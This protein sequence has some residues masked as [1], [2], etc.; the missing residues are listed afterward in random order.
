MTSTPTSPPTTTATSVP[1]ITTAD[2]T[3]TTSAYE[4]RSQPEVMVPE[5][6][7]PFPAV[8]LVHGGGWVAGTPSIMRPLAGH[9]TSAGFLTVNAAYALSDRQPGFPNALHDIACAIRFAS[10]HPDS[11]GTVVVVGHSAGAHLSAVVALTGDR[12]GPNCPFPGSGLPDKLVGLAGPYDVKQ[13]GPLMMPFFGG[14]PAVESDAWFAGNPM[15]L[16]AENPSLVSLLMHGDSDGIVEPRFTFDFEAAMD[17][18]GSE[19]LVEIVE[20]A[21]HQDLRDPAIVGDLIVTWLLR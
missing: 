12:Y 1:T 19:V 11:D 9:L 7:G 21:D 2:P 4:P 5:G 17:E 15:N 14:G 16:V 3:T 13:L 20:G 6:V 10:S 8:V 18:A